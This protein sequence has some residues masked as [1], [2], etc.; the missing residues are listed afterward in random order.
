MEW[1]PEYFYRCNGEP[2]ICHPARVHETDFRIKDFVAVERP[3][4]RTDLVF[5]NRFWFRKKIQTNDTKKSGGNCSS[6][7]LGEIL[8]LEAPPWSLH[9]YFVLLYEI[10]YKKNYLKYQCAVL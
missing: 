8:L 3:P 9:F 7:F 10:N 2:P 1:P 5:Y 6:S 4:L